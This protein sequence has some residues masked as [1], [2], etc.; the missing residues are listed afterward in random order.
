MYGTATE[1]PG[2]IAEHVSAYASKLLKGE[3]V[4]LTETVEEARVYARRPSSST[5]SSARRRSRSWR[6][7]PRPLA[8]GA[9]AS[10]GPSAWPSPTTAHAFTFAD[11]E[12]RSARAA[13]MLSAAGVGRGDRVA[14]QFPNVPAFVHLYFGVLRLGAVVVPINPLLKA[15]ETA[16]ALEDS[17]ARVLR[18]VARGREPRERSPSWFEILPPRSCSTA[19]SP[20][21]RSSRSSPRRRR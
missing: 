1:D 16:Y 18:G 14:L 3:E 21:T 15:A 12:L 2:T 11:V 8:A 17:G 7:Q 20:T 19:S 4:P 6:G 13:A 5:R 10:G 9:A